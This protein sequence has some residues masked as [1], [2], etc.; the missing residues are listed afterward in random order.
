MRSLL[1]LFTA[2]CAQ[3]AHAEDLRCR[4][5]I[6]KHPPRAAVVSDPQ[7]AKAVALIY[8][9]VIYGFAQMRNEL[10]LSAKIENG[11]W[12]VQ[13]TLPKDSEGGVA[14]IAICRKDGTVLSIFHEK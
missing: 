11:V 14:V 13:G 1:F 6:A 10:P 8:L 4:A 3:T 5:G 9:N 12:L 2:L 7:T